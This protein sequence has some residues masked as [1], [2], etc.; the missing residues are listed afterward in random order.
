MGVSVGMGVAVGVSLGVGVN[1][2]VYV[3]VGG[4]GVAVSVAVGTRTGVFVAV[5]VWVGV[6]VKVGVAVNV[7]VGVGVGGT[8]MSYSKAPM[9]QIALVSPSPSC[10]R[11]TPR[12]SVVSQ[13]DG[14]PA[15]MAGLPGSRAW[16][17]VLPP[18]SASA[19]SSGSM[20]EAMLPIRSPVAALQLQLSA[21]PI[22]L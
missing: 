14:L 13:L 10:G 7:G 16:V 19:P 21:L 17:S 12:W 22:R 5:G 6:A 4:I 11:V 2:G 1:V 8:G 20:G 9:S 15:S 3:G 18:L